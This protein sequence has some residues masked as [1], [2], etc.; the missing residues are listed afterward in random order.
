MKEARGNRLHDVWFYLYEMSRMG[1]STE[2]VA[3][4]L[5]NLP[6][7]QETWVQSLVQEDSLEK[8]MATHFSTL[9]WKS[10]W[11][12]EPGRLRYVRSQ[13]SDAT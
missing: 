7:V 6:A 12:E 4:S 3:Q 8:E 5:Q 11:T 13:E 1:K 10:P 2:T 9:A